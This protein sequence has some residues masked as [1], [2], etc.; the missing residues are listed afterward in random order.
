MSVFADEELQYLQSARLGRLATVGAD[1]MPHVV[2]TSFRYNPAHDT[3][4]IGGHDFGR[5]KKYRDALRHPQVAF[6]VDDIAS[7][8]PWRVRGIEVRG[9]VRVLETGG[10]ELGPGFAP[11]MFQ[12]T[13]RRIVSW[14]LGDGTSASARTVL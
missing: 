3:I 10:T 1:G 6:V 9:E 4:D 8:S 14:G 12:I 11:E 2:P 5:R 7:V 13:A